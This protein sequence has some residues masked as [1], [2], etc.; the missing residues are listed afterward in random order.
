LLDIFDEQEKQLI[1]KEFNNGDDSEAVRNA[2]PEEAEHIK[3]ELNTEF[4][5]H[6]IESKASPGLLRNAS[7][8]SVIYCPFNTVHKQEQLDNFQLTYLDDIKSLLQDRRTIKFGQGVREINREYEKFNNLDFDNGVY[9][10]FAY[11]NQ[12]HISRKT[13]TPKVRSQIHPLQVSIYTEIN[14]Q[15]TRD[16]HRRFGCWTQEQIANY[17][18]ENVANHCSATYYLLC[19]DQ[20]F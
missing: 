12:P 14:T 7:S 16:M 6:S 10:K 4:T 15:I 19:F 11:K 13:K 3:D 20:N 17:I 5:E 2:E 18:Q 9:H 1:R 8:R